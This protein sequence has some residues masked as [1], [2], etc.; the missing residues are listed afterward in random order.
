VSRYTDEQ[1]AESFRRARELLAEGDAWTPYEPAADLS[2]GEHAPLLPSTENRDDHLIRY[3]LPLAD[4]HRAERWRREAEDRRNGEN[5]M[6][7][8]EWAQWADRRIA[9]ALAEH[10]RGTEAA[11]GEALGEVREQLREEIKNAVGEL[12]AELTVK[13][14]HERGGPVIDLPALQFQRRGNAA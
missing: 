8:A 7:D 2:K 4:P 11:V 5:R 1:K 10:A 13:A 9:A 12:R 6:T 14:T 3:G